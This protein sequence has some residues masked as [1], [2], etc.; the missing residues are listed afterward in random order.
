MA[1]AQNLDVFMRDPLAFFNQSITRMHMIPRLELEQLQLEALRL[2]VAEH[3]DSIEMVRNLAARSG[4]TDVSQF[5]DVVPLLFEHTAF[6]SYPASLIDKCRFDLMTQWLDKHTPHDLSRVDTEGCEGID[7]WIDRLD[8]QTPLEVIT[9]SGT[10]GTISIIPKDRQGASYTMRVWRNFIFQSFGR[11]PTHEEL[12]PEVDVIWPNFAAGKLGH[13]R[14]AAMLKREFT[15]GDES[16]F[17]ALYSG[18]ISTDLMFLASKMRAAAS[19]GELDRLEID[20]KLLARKDEFAGAV[21]AVEEMSLEG[22]QR[23][24]QA[25]L[26]AF[27]T[28]GRDGGEPEVTGEDGRAALELAER[29]VE[30]IREVAW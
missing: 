7:A 18:S 23:P 8:E 11:E 6:K 22:E 26:D 24:L 2:R 12:Y 13:L 29:I 1:A 9:S 17:H 20:P 14:L 3:I 16:R 19:R 21:L 5:D 15:G 10:T 28:A 4:T 30:A 27:L 25:E